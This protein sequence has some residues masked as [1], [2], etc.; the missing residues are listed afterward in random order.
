MSL[1]I[2]SSTIVK[3]TVAASSSYNANYP[4]TEAFNGNTGDRENDR[5]VSANNYN[6][7]TGYPD[8]GAGDWYQFEFEGPKRI[9]KIKVYTGIYPENAPKKITFYVSPTGNFNGEEINCGTVEFSDIPLANNLTDWYEVP[10]PKESKY[11]RIVINKIWPSSNGYVIIPEWQLW[12][13]DETSNENEFGDSAYSPTNAFDNNLAEGNANDGAWYAHTSANGYQSYGKIGQ[14][15]NHQPKVIKKYRIYSNISS[16]DYNP[17]DWT[18]EGSNDST[19]GLS[20]GTWVVLD[21]QTGMSIKLGAGIWSDFSIPN[22]KSFK[23]YRL[24][25]TANGGGGYLIIQDIEML[26]YNSDLTDVILNHYTDSASDATFMSDNDLSTYIQ[27]FTYLAIELSVPRKVHRLRIGMYSSLSK[28]ELI[29]KEFQGSNDS[30][31]GS[32]GTWETLLTFTSKNLGS[33]Q[34]IPKFSNL[35]DVEKTGLY[36]WY[37]ITGNANNNNVV[38]QWELFDDPFN[39]DISNNVS[40]I[41]KEDYID[42]RLDNFPLPIKLNNFISSFDDKTRIFFIDEDFK[43]DTLDNSI[44]DTFIQSNAS[45]AVSDKL[46]LNNISGDNHSGAK[47]FT[48]D[49]FNT[50]GKYRL[51]FNWKPHTNHYSSA[52]MPGI[53]FCSPT[54]SRE[55]DYG[56]RQTGFIKCFLAKQQDTTERTELSIYTNDNSSNTWHGSEQST[57]SIDIDESIYHPIIIEIDWDEKSV[58]FS[59]DNNSYSLSAT[60]PD[61][62]LTAIQ[63]QFVLEIFT[64]DYNRNNT[65]IFKDVKFSRYVNSKKKILVTTDMTDI[66]T[67]LLIHSDSPTESTIFKDSSDR[68]RIISKYGDIKHKIDK[69]KLGLSSIYF[70]G[71]GDYL[72]V[73]DDEDFDLSSGDWTIDLWLYNTSLT[74]DNQNILN[75]D[76][77]ASTTYPQYALQISSSGNLEISLSDLSTSISTYTISAISLSRIISV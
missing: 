74:S 71:D 21:T 40:L 53:C 38:T 15:F 3:A 20:D 10:N 41:L 57:Q 47:I 26:S 43:G 42:S 66:Y 18:F 65:E 22:N 27:N 51:T 4:A 61:T 44:W 31:N 60:I 19:N 35:M 58:S 32:D 17:E 7:S 9:E 52:A 30:T 29:G 14:N 48:R 2:G 8:S 76:G 28:T 13:S 59:I 54:A 6:E 56:E 1:F 11:F 64:S 39:L 68:D 49:R 45:I 33:V 63:D 62:V 75:K 36:K 73:A 77:E 34:S 55:S 46:E 37:R 24:N 16:S 23:Y 25:I 72:T 67:K 50:S 12:D 5:W 69:F 70:D